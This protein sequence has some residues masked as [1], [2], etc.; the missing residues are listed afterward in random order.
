M[1]YGTG[2]EPTVARLKR[3]NSDLAE[4]AD[5]RIGWMT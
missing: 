5:S 2:T 3:D 1:H 4:R